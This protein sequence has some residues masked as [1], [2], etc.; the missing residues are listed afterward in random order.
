MGRGTSGA[1]RRRSSDGAG[2]PADDRPAAR[3][4]PCGAAT[5][6]P[7]SCSTSATTGAS[8]PTCSGWSRTTAARRTSRRRSSS[9]RC[10]ACARPSSRSPSSRGSTRSPRTPAS[11]RSAAPGAPR[12]SP[13]T[14]TTPSAPADHARLVAAG[15]SP[16]AAVAAKQELDHLCGAF[17]GL[18]ETAPRDPRPARARGPLLPRDRRPHGHEPPGRRVARSSAPAGA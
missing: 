9:P 10:A 5:T 1:W 7:S 18:S 6:A 4:A 15:P 12:R 8:T 14:P 13:T 16:D 3:R 17:G 11:T 2:S